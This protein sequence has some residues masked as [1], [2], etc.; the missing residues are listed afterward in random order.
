M[1]VSCAHLS[2]TRRIKPKNT[3]RAF[4]NLLVFI[5]A[6][7]DTERMS[8]E[9]IH[10]ARHKLTV[11]DYYRMAEV[12]ILAPDARVEL[13]EGE[14]ID[15]APIGSRHA[16]VVDKLVRLLNRAV[17]NRAIVRARG[18]VRLSRHT[19]PE[20]DIALLK[21]REDFY[22]SAHPGPGDILLVIEVSDSTF[23]YDREV[24]APLYARA[25]IPEY[26]L[27]DIEH[28]RVIFHRQPM[29]GAYREVSS[30]DRLGPVALAA[31][32][33]VVVDISGMP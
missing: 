24:K 32:E 25:E 33:E 17:G 28:G 15:M 11:T 7:P 20:P 18:S 30:S 14:I 4:V 21:Y 12:G 19:E 29:E 9:S 27:F 16:S 3:A 5:S 8:A 10:I 31:A 6:G 2:R 1:R 22:V 26:W 13:I 23:V